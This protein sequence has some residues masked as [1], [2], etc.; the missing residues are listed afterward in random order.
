MKC[1]DDCVDCK[2]TYMN[3]KCEY[4]VFNFLKSKSHQNGEEHVSLWLIH[5]NPLEPHLCV[6]HL[7]A[8]YL[9]MY[10]ESLLK[11]ATLF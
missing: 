11:A 3:V 9:C 7:L 4:L 6:V 2:I 5:V 8:R 10:P 1:T